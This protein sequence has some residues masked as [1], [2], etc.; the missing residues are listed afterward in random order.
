MK[1]CFDV[2][3]PSLLLLGHRKLSC[4]SSS[5]FSACWADVIYFFS[6]C[7]DYIRSAFMYDFE[8]N[9]V[10]LIDSSKKLGSF[11]ASFID[12]HLSTSPLLLV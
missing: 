8:V 10:V 11:E 7:R 3:F 12:I 5:L 9:F 4:Y 6:R 1:V 2:Y